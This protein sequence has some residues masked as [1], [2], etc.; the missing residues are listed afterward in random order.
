[1]IPSTP[2]PA[3]DAS[4]ARDFLP[5]KMSMPFVDRDILCKCKRLMRGTVIVAALLGGCATAPEKPATRAATKPPVV[6]YALSLQGTPYRYGKES[7]SEGFDCSGFVKHVYQHHGVQLPRT[8]KAMAQALPPVD[9]DERRPGDL[10]FFNT[11]G[12]AYS[13]VGI[14]VGNDSF[15][16][17]PSSH[18]GRVIV[19][20]LHLPYWWHRFIGVRR[21]AA[22]ERLLTRR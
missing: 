20:S 3:V 7:P 18:T 15:V 8:V 6:G 12:R 5:S 10:L 21:P 22:T 17:A 16:H 19:S 1:M 4:A 2:A 11:S 14:Y 9:K 13:H